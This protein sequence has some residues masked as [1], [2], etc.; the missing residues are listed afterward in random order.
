[1]YNIYICIC[2]YMRFLGIGFLYFLIFLSV[3]ILGKLSSHAR[4][5]A[6]YLFQKFSHFNASQWL[7]NFYQTTLSSFMS[8]YNSVPCL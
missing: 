1:M 7:Q 3:H 8:L 4:K 6:I 5:A 2:I